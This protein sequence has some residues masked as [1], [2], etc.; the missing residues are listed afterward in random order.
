MKLDVLRQHLQE[1]VNRLGYDLYD[2]EYVTERKQNI[3][4]VLIDNDAGVSIDD[5][6]EVSHAL[7]P[8]LDELD[9]IPNEYSLEV[10]SPGAERKLRNPDEI[11]K[12][13]GK[14]VHL[15]TYEQKIEGELIRFDGQTIIINDKHNKQVS[16]DYIEVN[17]IRLAIK[18]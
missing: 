1:V 2:V 6:V 5:C 13:V 10:A 11:K 7:D 12:A 15:E 18:F 3:L 16:F 4:R 9:P 14:Y 17:H 8:V